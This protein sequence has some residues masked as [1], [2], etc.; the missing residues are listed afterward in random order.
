MLQLELIE[1]E[2]IEML[3]APNPIVETFDVIE[4]F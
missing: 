2:L 4:G 3:V 1:T